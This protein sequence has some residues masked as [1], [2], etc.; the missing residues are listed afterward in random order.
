PLS[1]L[2]LMAARE[3]K[4]VKLEPGDTVVL[5]SSMIPGNEPA[6]HRVIDGLYRAGAEA[7]HVPVVPVHGSGH[8]AADELKM[9]LNLIRPRWFTRVHGDRRHLNTHGRRAPRMRSPMPQCWSSVSDPRFAG[10]SGRR[11]STSRR[12]SR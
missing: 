8:A 5:S 9:I 4:F 12:S 7:F 2:S 6:I 10:R 3:H 1:A 11:P